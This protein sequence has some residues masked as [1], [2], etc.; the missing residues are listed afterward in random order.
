M[1]FVPP[2]RL[3]H[4]EWI[5]DNIIHHDDGER[6]VPMNPISFRST[7]PTDG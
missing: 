5:P 1:S 3:G 7:K 4:D 6:L 2:S